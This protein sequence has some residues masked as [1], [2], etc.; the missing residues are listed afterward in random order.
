MTRFSL[1]AVCSLLLLALLLPGLAP[2]AGDAAANHGGP[3]TS[4]LSLEAASTLSPTLTTVALP[5]V[6]R[7]HYSALQCSADSPF[8]LQIAA[9]HQVGATAGRA[10]DYRPLAEAEWWARYEAAFPALLEALRAS[11]ACWSRVRI[12]WSAIQDSAPPA[13]YYLAWHDDKLR[14]VA[15][16]GLRMIAQIDAVPDWAGPYTCGPI[17]AEHLA[18]F[19][20]FV[21][22][23]VNHYK[24]P[25]YNIHHWELFNEPDGTE[26]SLPGI[27][28]WGNFGAAY[29]AMLKV[30]YPAIKAADPEATVLMGGLAYDAFVEYGLRFN[31]Y[32]PDAVMAEGGGG[33]IDALALHYFPDY[34]LE[35]ERWVPPAD[36][37]TCGNVEDGEGDEYHIRPGIRDLTAKTLHFTNRL[38][39]CT[40]VQKPVWITELAEHGYSPNPETNYP[41]TL[42]Q[43]ARYVIQGYARGLAAGVKNITWYALVSPPGDPFAQGLLYE[44]DWSPKPAYFAYQTL[45][46]ELK[47]HSYVR[48]LA[49]PGVE[50]YIFRGSDGR[51]KTV[52]WAWDAAAPA[53]LTLAPA[54]RVRVV[55]RDRTVTVV[56]D[57]GPGDLD[58]LQN[59]AVTLA[60]TAEPVFLSY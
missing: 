46:A 16:T 50:G 18:A 30:A 31:R 14:Q 9:L 54:G 59:G 28:C 8:S 5:I 25:P 35:W 13:P 21:T 23:L 55:S 40:N 17:D 43:Q 20:Q 2:S 39:T 26:V 6:V 12:D 52:A 27:G 33:F 58:G 15:A 47:D 48:M 42:D 56:E 1:P 10:A 37:P 29:A 41:G 44:T 4:G 60:M 45:A 34:H 38:A 22:A 7:N 24:L 19:G 53:P 11:G 32:F 57:G 3:E 49:A 51:E 36:P